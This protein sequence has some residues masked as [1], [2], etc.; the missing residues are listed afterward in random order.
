MIINGES[1]VELSKL[2]DNSVDCI[3]TDPPYGIEFMALSF[4]KV[5][6]DKKIWEECF[7]V[8]KSG[9]FAFIMT[10]TRQSL[11]AR[12]ILDLEE[13]GFNTNFSSIFWAFASGFPKAHNISKALEKKGIKRDN[14]NGAY[15]GFQPKPALEI[16]VKCQKPIDE[17]TE[18]IYLCMELISV[19]SNTIKYVNNAKTNSSTIPEKILKEYFAQEIV[20]LNITEEI[21]TIV[22]KVA[23]SK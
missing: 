16:I 15:A 10:S 9:S 4:D 18:L 1:S 17:K 12:L 22:G 11:M 8:M 20:I 14:S 23:N 7:R 6:P 2:D 13:V 3:V 5:L 19:W 21:N